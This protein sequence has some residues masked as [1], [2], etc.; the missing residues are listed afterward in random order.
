MFLSDIISHANTE[1]NLSLPNNVDIPSP[2]SPDSLASSTSRTSPVSLASPT[3]LASSASFSSPQELN[4][5]TDSSK[6]VAKLPYRKRKK[7][8]AA[9]VDLM[10]VN[11]LKEMNAAPKSTPISSP[12]VGKTMDNK[13][14]EHMFCQ[15]LVQQLKSLP[16]QKN[17]LARI[18]IQQVL[19]DIEFS[20]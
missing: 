8:I 17:K 19:Y 6:Y 9:N 13:D 15:S 5:D 16:A 1:S 10:L 20:D 2:V 4:T 12:D 11:T 18:K 7:D 3:S 14:S